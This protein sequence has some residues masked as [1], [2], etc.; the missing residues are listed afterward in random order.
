[1]RGK[2]VKGLK[3]IEGSKLHA[4]TACLSWCFPKIIDDQTIRRKAGEL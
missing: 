2:S 1:M 4:K 3:C